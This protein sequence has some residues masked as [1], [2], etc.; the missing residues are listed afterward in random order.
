MAAACETIA[1]YASREVV[2]FPALQRELV[3]ELDV[4]DT[5]RA[6]LQRLDA[7]IAELSRAARG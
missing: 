6:C 2:D 1:L 7:A 5:Q 3:R 4:F